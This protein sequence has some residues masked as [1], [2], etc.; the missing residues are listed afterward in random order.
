VNQTLRERTDLSSLCTKKFKAL[1]K[2]A[3][4]GNGVSIPI[5]SIL[6]YGAWIIL[7]YQMYS[8]SGDEAP[9]AVYDPYVLL[10]VERGV[11]AKEV[12][13][14]YRELSKIHHPDKNPDD[15]S[16]PDIDEFELASLKFMEL[17]KAHDALTDPVTM[18]NFEKYGN[19]DGPQSMQFGIALPSWIVDPK[20]SFMVIGLYFFVFM[21]CL[22][23]VVG[24]WWYKAAKFYTDSVMLNTMKIFGS[25]LRDQQPIKTL[26]ER[27]CWSEEFQFVPVRET[28]DKTF[29]PKYLAQFKDDLPDYKKFKFPRLEGIVV[30][31]APAI[32]SRIL[33]Y[34]HKSR[35]HDELKGKAAPLLED[36]NYCVARVPALIEAMIEV[37]QG[38]RQVSLLK[39]IMNL[40]QM[41]IQAVDRKEEEPLLQVPHFTER[42]LKECHK[43]KVKVNSIEELFQLDEETRNTVVLKDFDDRQL[44]DVKRFGQCFP[45]LDVSHDL[46]V[47]G[48]DK[49][50]PS[51]GYIFDGGSTVTVTITLKRLSMDGVTSLGVSGTPKMD[52]LVEQVE[53]P[54]KVSDGIPE[55]Y[56]KKTKKIVKKKGKSSTAAAA[57]APVPVPAAEGGAD[58][59]A[60]AAAAAEAEKAPEAP[61]N[62]GGEKTK[63][64]DSS[65]SNSS[66]SDSDSDSGNKDDEDS[67]EDFI[68]PEF[69]VD[70]KRK[71]KLKEFKRIESYPVHCPYFPE[72]KDEWW[73]VFIAH[74]KED[75]ALSQVVTVKNLKDEEQVE[76]ML[77]MPQA[78]GEYAIR[79]FVSSDSYQ[80]IDREI[81]IKFNVVKGAAP[82]EEH[83]PLIEEEDSDAFTE[84]ES[85]GDDSDF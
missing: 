14:A 24:S 44:E 31:A 57:P 58:A 1:E 8:I 32:K 79:L 22:P 61:A 67:D 42:T 23:F 59:P 46:S 50:D 48:E 76:L 83:N 66:D 17:T 39:S 68:P 72:E 49:S 43:K 41:M 84:S 36:L 11:T 26:I 51:K 19:P 38:T 78:P 33:L 53:A 12:K 52:M 34:I 30:K 80:G 6:Y 75:M 27:M 25:Y 64:S 69:E 4:Q 10:G 47:K 45:F 63:Q 9:E 5:W 81:P 85:D 60:A 35:G 82:V 71:Q 13:K 37:A 40:S 3:K 54:K 28:V 65:D 77:P 74:S 55:K 2:R 15:K 29:L 73:W 16:T 7:A 20:N 62:D 56:R 18:E 70:S 21:V